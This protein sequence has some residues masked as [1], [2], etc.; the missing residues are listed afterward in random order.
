MG[1]Y[2]VPESL[3]RGAVVTSAGYDVLESF[4]V[5]SSVCMVCEAVFDMCTYTPDEDSCRYVYAIE[6]GLYARG[7]RIVEVVGN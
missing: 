5:G 7:T 2:C 4:H 3:E 1:H 6:G